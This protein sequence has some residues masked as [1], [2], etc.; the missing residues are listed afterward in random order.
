LPADEKT[1]FRFTRWRQ[2]RALSQVLA[3]LGAS[4]TADERYFSP[5]PRV[6]APVVTLGG[7][8]RARLIQRWLPRRPPTRV[9][10]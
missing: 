6:K 3:N 1:Y 7:E 8:W 10:R 9:T 4:F 2:T 5:R